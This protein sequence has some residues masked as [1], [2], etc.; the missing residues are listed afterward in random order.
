MRFRTTL[1]FVLVLIGL[2]AYVYWVEVPRSREETKK[3]TVFALN[4]DDITEV[5]LVYA[6]RQVVVKK[7]GGDWRLT[8]PIDAMADA[9]TI[10]NMINAIADAEVT[11]TFEN[12]SDLVPYG[13]DQPFVKVTIAV[14]DNALPTI[15]VGKATPVGYSAYIK[16][17]N[18]Q[19]VLLTTA[20]FRAGMDKQAKDLRDK[21]IVSFADPD[22]QRVEIAGD[23]KD[24]AL[25]QTDNHWTIERPASYAADA[26]AMSGFLSALRSMRAVDFA[27]DSPTDLSAFGLDKP[28]LTV[29]LYLGRDKAETDILIGKENENK[30]LYVKGSGQ[31]TVYLV[32]DWVLRDLDKTANDFRDKTVLAFDRD[33]VTKA[34][35]VR[36]DGVHFS[37]VRSNRQ[38]QVEGAGEGTVSQTAIDRYIGDLRDLVGYEILADDPGNLAAFGL[39][40]PLLKVRLLG[41]ADHSLGTILLGARAGDAALKDYTAMAEGGRTVFKIRDYQ[42]TR[43][44]K[45]PQ[46]FNEPPTPAP[47]LGPESGMPGALSE[48]LEGEPLGDDLGAIPGEVPAGQ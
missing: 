2:A 13:L 10:R 8:Q 36:H 40:L 7:S 33:K 38:W 5:S 17:S 1:I 30:Q 42:F 47:G 48:E 37:L 44:D 4:P 32:S 11:K 14:K 34:D 18:E 45:R 3:K 35:V 31:P 43:L 22:V 23:G 15:L 12:V 46:D 29:R 24:V 20:A 6:D 19:N 25:V 26:S 41:E 9:A 28:R 16:K 27:A 39:D 21:T